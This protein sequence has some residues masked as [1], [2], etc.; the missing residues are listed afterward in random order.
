MQ[1]R[2]II[3]FTVNLITKYEFILVFSSFSIE[4]KGQP[5]HELYLISHINTKT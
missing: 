5:L 2:F 3:G 1:I 4:G